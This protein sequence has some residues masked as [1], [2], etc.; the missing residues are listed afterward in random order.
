M[1]S[2]ISNYHHYN[3]QH[4]KN[5]NQTVETKENEDIRSVM[6]CPLSYIYGNPL[7]DV[8]DLNRDLLT[9]DLTEVNDY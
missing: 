8:D 1:K 9:E 5:T 7:D 3:Q 6:D 2:S 4:R